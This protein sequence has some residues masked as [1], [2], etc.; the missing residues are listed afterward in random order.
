MLLG[1]RVGLL[2]GVTSLGALGIA[3]LD[4]DVLVDRLPVREGL[5]GQVSLQSLR[6]GRLPDSSGNRASDGTTNVTEDVE[7]S[8]GT[9]GVLVVGSSQDSNLHDDDEGTTGE[10]HENLTHDQISNA[11]VRLAEVD[12]Q[13]NAKQVQGNDPEKQ[14][15]VAAGLA[16]ENAYAEKPHAGDNVKDV[17]DVASNS[18]GD[19]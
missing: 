18:D 13:A 8:K 7:E 4:F 10:S 5:R 15:A 6:E 14:P 19:S 1:N 3:D 11:L 17:R 16:D 12:H 2:D 9:G